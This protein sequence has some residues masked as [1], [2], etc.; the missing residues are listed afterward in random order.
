VE[1][2]VPTTQGMEAAEEEEESREDNSK[3]PSILN[4]VKED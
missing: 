3:E 4:V 1:S 2:V